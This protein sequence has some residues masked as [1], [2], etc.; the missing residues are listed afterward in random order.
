V[1]H[2]VQAHQGQITVDSEPGSGA[3]FTIRLPLDRASGTV[4]A[5]TETAAKA[6]DVEAESGA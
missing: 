1:A 5:A 3:T 2:V 4:P 6:P